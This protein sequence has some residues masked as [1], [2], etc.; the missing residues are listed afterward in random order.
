MPQK[1]TI[2]ADPYKVYEQALKFYAVLDQL[3]KT[4]DVERITLIGVPMSVLAAF[5]SELFFKCL[6]CLETGS[7]SREHLLDSLFDE[8]S[9]ETQSIVEKHWDAI[10]LQNLQALDRLDV[11]LGEKAPRDLR[12]NLASGR[13]GFR[14]LRYV[15]EGG[16]DF[17]FTLGL[18]PIALHN[19]I[20]EIKPDWVAQPQSV[21]DKPRA[22]FVKSKG[23]TPI[24]RFADSAVIDIKATAFQW[25]VRWS[26]NSKN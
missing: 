19:T 7:L 21:V 2:T 22:A 13:D 23:S 24:L 25:A 10:S 16:S 9:S 18:L 20:G 15:Y 11:S 4:S 5:A 12:S 3:H 14:L 1:Q 8:L 6:A 17:K 26:A